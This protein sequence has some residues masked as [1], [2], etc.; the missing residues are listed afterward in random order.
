MRPLHRIPSAV[1]LSCLGSEDVQKY[2]SLRHLTP[3]MPGVRSTLQKVSLPGEEYK[4]GS[5]VSL[6]ETQTGEIFPVRVS[7]WRD[8][9]REDLPGTYLIC[10]GI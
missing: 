9:G 4:K 6:H 1:L 2:T 8:T 3:G 10:A 5:D 7:M